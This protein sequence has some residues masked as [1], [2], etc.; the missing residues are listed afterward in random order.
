MYEVHAA[1]YYYHR[2]AYLSAVNRAQVAL[3]NYPRTTSNDE[4]LWLMISSYEKLGLADLANDTR[5]VLE[6]SYP[7]SEWLTGGPK[8]KAWW[9]FW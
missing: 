2:G 8:K 4:A 6:T 3:I 5:R 9:K 1:R 7:D